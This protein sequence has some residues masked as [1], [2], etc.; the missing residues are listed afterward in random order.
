MTSPRSRTSRP[1]RGTGGR[2]LNKKDLEDHVLD[3]ED[4]VLEYADKVLEDEDDRD[5]SV[6]RVLEVNVL[7]DENREDVDLE[8]KH[9][10]GR[11]PMS[12]TSRTMSARY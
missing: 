7:V 11:S 3:V 8:N 10:E 12:R 5:L 6:Y 1:R 4:D 2:A 9:L